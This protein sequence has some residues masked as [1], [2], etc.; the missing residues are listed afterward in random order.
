MFN[1]KVSRL[2]IMSTVGAVLLG[3]GSDSS[4]SSSS[5]VA[6][7]QY[8][9]ASSN[10]TSTSLVLDDYAYTAIDFADAMPRYGYSVGSSDL[11]IYGQD[12]DG[13]TVTVYSDT[14][15]LEPM[16]TICLCYMVII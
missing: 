14:V 4:D 2:I 13:E 5:D 16:I 10:S 7:V 1:K 12:E 8:Y 9:N 15:E 6:Y 3:C 11:E